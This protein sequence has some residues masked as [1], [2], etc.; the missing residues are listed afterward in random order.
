MKHL[1]PG[2]HF[3]LELNKLMGMFLP[4]LVCGIRPTGQCVGLLDCVQSQKNVLNSGDA[5][6][7]QGIVEVPY[8]ELCL[9]TLVGRPAQRLSGGS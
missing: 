9:V 5:R 4:L 2:L 7:F 1:H 3:I 6:A 8:Q